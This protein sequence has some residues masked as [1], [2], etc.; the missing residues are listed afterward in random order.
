MLLPGRWAR[1]VSP[2]G[3]LNASRSRSAA[4]AKSVSGAAAAKAWFSTRPAISWPRTRSKW[5]PRSSARST[6]SASIRATT[7]KEGQVLVRLEDDEY[8][9][10]V[11]QAQ[12]A[13]CQPCRPSWM[14][15]CTGRVPRRSPRRKANLNSPKPTS[16]TPRS[17]STARRNWS[18]R[19][20]SPQQSLDDAQARYDS[21]CAQGQLAA[22]DATTW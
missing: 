10:Q 1:G 9:A 8:Q 21:R 11:Q 20:S 17:L 15:R 2:T 14:R 18:P 16:R 6:G 22:E 4:R 5:P 13:A 19:R 7:C 3:K 12:G